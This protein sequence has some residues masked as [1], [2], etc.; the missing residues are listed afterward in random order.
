[1]QQ[2][3]QQMAQIIDLQNG[4]QSNL[5][6]QVQAATG[7][8][9]AMLAS[10]RP[11]TAEAKTTTNGLGAAVGSNGSGQATAAAQRAMDVN[12]PNK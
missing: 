11:G 6:G 12:N 7:S 9:S 3:M 1:M 4:G 2:Q 5:T 10:G 8:Q